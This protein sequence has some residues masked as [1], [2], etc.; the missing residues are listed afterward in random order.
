MN[1]K[2][3]DSKSAN[4]DLKTDPVAVK[5]DRKTVAKVPEIKSRTGSKTTKPVKKEGAR[6]KNTQKRADVVRDRILAAALE[7]FGA[8]GFDGAST[9]T[10]AEFAGV[11]HTLVL[12]HFKS[13]DQLWIAT[14]EGVLSKYGQEMH[15][16]LS[17]N[18]EKTA[19]L[20]LK[21]FI[22]QFVRFSA[23]YP[24]IHRIFTSEGNQDTERLKWV[25]DHFLRDH[26]SL[27]VDIIRRGQSEGTV[28]Q[29]DP[30]RL[31]F[32]II[33][34]GGTPFT[35]STEYKELTGRNVFS[36]AEIL[37]N[38]AFIYEIVFD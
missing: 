24:Q 8:Q 14:V 17:C 37:R 13:K 34:V 10:I 25:I 30:A 9:R 26:F 15:D 6:K 11:T 38:I 32:L 3:T 36:E 12:Y 28:R 21:I 33:G 22:D 4:M 5:Q 23:R 16:N 2:S 19:S 1:Q 27:I 18:H 20:A 31:Y 29:C 35:I 7:C